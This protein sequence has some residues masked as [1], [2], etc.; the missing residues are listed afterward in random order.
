MEAD[1]LRG[2]MGASLFIHRKGENIVVI[3]TL[4]SSVCR[5]PVE[6]HCCA[7]STSNKI[8]LNKAPLNSLGNLHYIYSVLFSL[9]TIY[10]NLRPLPTPSPPLLP[11][12]LFCSVVF[13]ICILYSSYV[14]YPE[15]DVNRKYQTHFERINFKINS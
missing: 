3:L 2:N 10:S 7:S 15:N 4:F 14:K 9:V 12:C 1:K 13:K 5:R 6:P 8:C 11:T